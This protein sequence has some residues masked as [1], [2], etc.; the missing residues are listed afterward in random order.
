[1]RM[2]LKYCVDNPFI[3]VHFVMCICIS[4]ALEVDRNPMDVIIPVH[5]MCCPRRGAILMK[6]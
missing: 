3:I 4:Y 2:K 5:I 6:S 1:M